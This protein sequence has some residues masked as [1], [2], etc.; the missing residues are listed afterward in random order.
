MFKSY[1]SR[2]SASLFS[3]GKFWSRQME[4]LMSSGVVVMEIL[5]AGEL[6]TK[7]LGH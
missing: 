5:V 7:I 2:V 6:I 1:D 4:F 3:K